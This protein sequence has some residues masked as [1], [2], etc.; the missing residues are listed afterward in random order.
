M[1]RV[2]V[3]GKLVCRSGGAARWAVH[4]A[5]CLLLG[6]ATLGRDLRSTPEA[7]RARQESSKEPYQT[8][9]LCFDGK[10]SITPCPLSGSLAGCCSA[11]GGVYRN[12]WG[13]AVV[14]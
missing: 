1:R 3:A 6:C 7:S 9:P 8:Y 11:Q 13:D 14:E 12:A 2:N 5:S 10:P 4:L